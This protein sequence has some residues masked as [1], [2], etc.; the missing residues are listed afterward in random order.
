MLKDK[1]IASMRRAVTEFN[2]LDD[3]GRQTSVLLGLHHACEMLLKAGLR[4]RG[5][6]VFDKRSAG[7]LRP[8]R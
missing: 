5:A 2:T 3:E 1:A 8:G 4:E 7:A 6:E